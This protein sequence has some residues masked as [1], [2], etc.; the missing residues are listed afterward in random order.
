MPGPWNPRAAE[1]AAEYDIV[2]AVLH[3]IAAALFGTAA[4]AW[5]SAGKG[6]RGIPLIGG[7]GFPGLGANERPIIAQTGEG[8][9]SRQGMATIGGPAVV[10][11]ANRGVSIGSQ[12]IVVTNT[13]GPIQNLADVEEIGVLI[14]EKILSTIR[15]SA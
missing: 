4:G 15:E 13:M 12:S 8:L 1:S 6:H 5:S 7:A 3:A 10:E 11:A 2:G 9:L 14:G